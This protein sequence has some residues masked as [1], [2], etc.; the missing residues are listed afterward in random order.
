LERGACRA[1]TLGKRTPHS[2]L[3]EAMSGISNLTQSRQGASRA[4][5]RTHCLGGSVQPRTGGSHCG[6][7]T[8]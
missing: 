7:S 8:D 3:H 4:P 2:S 5:A 1:A 6:R